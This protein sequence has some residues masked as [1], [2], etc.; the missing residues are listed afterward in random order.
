MFA[1]S[2]GVSPFSAM[3]FQFLCVHYILKSNLRLKHSPFYDMIHYTL[4]AIR[5]R[6]DYG[7]H[8]PSHLLVTVFP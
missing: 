6:G 8:I 7:S 2:A 3:P 5:I 1:T 4:D